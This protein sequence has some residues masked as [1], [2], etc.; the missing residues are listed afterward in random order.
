MRW[1][2]FMDMADFIGVMQ[3]LR[4]YTTGKFAASL[5]PVRGV[6]V[7][8]IPLLL[9]GRGVLE[10]EEWTDLCEGSPGAGLFDIS[11]PPQSG[12]EEA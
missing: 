3:Y 5:D 2:L 11:W 4:P 9:I 8:F 6:V 10:W 12:C 7:H 1:V